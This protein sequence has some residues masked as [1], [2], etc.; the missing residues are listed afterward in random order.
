[1]F[2]EHYWKFQKWNIKIC[3]KNENSQNLFNKVKSFQLS[4]LKILTVCI[5]SFSIY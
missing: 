1:M 3:N 5:T 4:D 2:K